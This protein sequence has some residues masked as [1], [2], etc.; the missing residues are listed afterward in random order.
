MFRYFEDFAEGEEIDLGKRF[1]SAEEIIEFA[2]EFDP[3]PFHLSEEGGR[4]SMLGALSASGWHTCSMLMAM[5]C[6]A[7][8]LN[9][10]GQGGNNVDECRWLAPVHAG[11]ILSGRT[12]VLSKR[13]S[14]SRPGLGIIAVKS[15]LFKQSGIA[16]LTLSNV[17][18]MRTSGSA[19]EEKRQ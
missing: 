3:A 5:M 9:S 1:V 13:L 8:L 18:M 6:D 14:A 16:V 7:F 15:E 11:D 12:T 4:N 19:A 17:I 2:T 10:A